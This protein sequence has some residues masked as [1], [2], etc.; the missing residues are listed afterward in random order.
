MEEILS[1]YHSGHIDDQ[2]VQSV[3]AHALVCKA[4]RE[5]LRVMQIMSGKSISDTHEHLSE[6]LLTSYYERPEMF[7]NSATRDIESHLSSCE[8]CR[9]DLEFLVNLE[10]D[11]TG[12]EINRPKSE[13]HSQS[14]FYR[15]SDFLKHPALAYLLVA[16]MMYP[17]IS[18][19]SGKLS[20]A[21]ESQTTQRSTDTL[22]LSSQLRSGGNIQVVLRQTG[23]PIVQFQIPIYHVT[24][25][26]SYEF[27]FRD[28]QADTAINVEY[29]S[30]YSEESSLH[31]TVNTSSL[32]DAEYILEVTERNSES[33]EISKHLRF[34]FRLETE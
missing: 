19:L 17:T 1:D 2:N 16:S 30:D 12:K 4:C 10:R 21:P 25:I 33:D 29:L 11:L 5:T 34:T 32:A 8:T 14:I 28:I 6:K 9:A 18:W 3:E 15:I 26:M 23:A 22:I 27:S 31:L 20:S 24:E 7:V 13:Y